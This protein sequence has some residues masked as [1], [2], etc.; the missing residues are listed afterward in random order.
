MRYSS[1]QLRKTREAILSEA[2]KLF[3]VKGFHATS[4]DNVMEA[5]GL[6]RGSFYS[7]FSSKEDLFTQAMKADLNFTLALRDQSSNLTRAIAAYLDKDSMDRIGCACTL[8]TLTP[9]VARM[10]EQT[11]AAFTSSF[12]DLIEE[13]GREAP[14]RESAL[15]A[16]LAS[17]GSLTLAR[18]VNCPEL[19][20]EIL[21]A[22]KKQ[23]NSALERCDKAGLCND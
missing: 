16:I 23:A 4:I 17:V 3:R 22:G 6:T 10:K 11:R 9:E 14:S 15:Q 2:N 19:A 7:H 5:A 21:E 13:F 12:G 8:V 1:V 20:S 18:A